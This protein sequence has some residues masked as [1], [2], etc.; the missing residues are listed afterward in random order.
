LPSPRVSQFDR[1]RIVLSN[2]GVV[3]STL[4]NAAI[5]K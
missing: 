1:T 5:L 3:N 4:S 2:K